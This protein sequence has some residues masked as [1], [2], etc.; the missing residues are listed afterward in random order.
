MTTFYL[1]RHA[2]ANWIPDE[3]RPLS[4][5]GKQDA[6]W[7]ANK[8]RP[9]PITAIYSSPFRR[10]YQTVEPLAKR[11]KLPIQTLP[12]LRERHL[13]DQP[14][15]DFTAAI[16]AVWHDPTFAYPGGE[17]HIT[18][19]QRGLA[20]LNALRQQHA[21]DQIVL[22]THGTLMTLIL[23]HFEPTIGYEFWQTLRMPDIYSL[24][25]SATRQ[26]TITQM[27]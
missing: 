12:D 2:H 5:Q 23:Q 20:V 24:Q 14:V 7:V 4:A 16:G 18:A 27:A 10:A 11:L 1:V 25:L 9:F 21:T 13:A 26:A 6:G 8:L 3:N 15:E 22:G 17:P 19:Q